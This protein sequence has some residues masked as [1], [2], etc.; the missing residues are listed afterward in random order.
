MKVLMVLGS[1][2][3]NGNSARLAEVVRDAAVECGATV[4]T[5]SLNQLT[6]RGCQA[7]D[8]CK[9]VSDRCTLDDDLKGVLDAVERA[10]VLVLATPVYFS[11]VSAQTK[12]FI[13]RCYSFLAPYETV[14]D[15]SRLAPGKRMVFIVTQNWPDA[16]VFGDIFPRYDQMFQAIGIGNNICVR[17]VGL[18][19]PVAI[20]TNGRIDLL[21]A[22]RA[23]AREVFAAA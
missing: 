2:R 17:G 18:G 19:K 6:F 11:D 4:K 10:D 21:E 23:T 5:V 9:T 16:E 14:P 1:P 15:A 12:A 8:A 7:C 20:D 3:K 13:D 22:A